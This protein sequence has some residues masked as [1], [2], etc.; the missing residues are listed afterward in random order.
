MR[1]LVFFGA[2][3]IYL[4]MA[5]TNVFVGYLLWGWAGLIA[6]NAYLY[7]FMSGIGYVQLFA[8]ITFISIIINKNKLK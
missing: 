6:L 5:L 7:G 2:L 3:M 4:P 8:I 1:D